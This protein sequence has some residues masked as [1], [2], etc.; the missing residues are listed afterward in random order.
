MRTK[1]KILGVLKDRTFFLC[2]EP[3]QKQI[4][5]REFILQKQN[6]VNRRFVRHSDVDVVVASLKFEKPKIIPR[7]SKIVLSCDIMLTCAT[8]ETAFETQMREGV[9]SVTSRFNALEAS[10]IRSSSHSL[11]DDNH[12]FVHANKN[13]LTGLFSDY[14]SSNLNVRLFDFDSAMRREDNIH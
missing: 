2:A 4:H 10:R 7:L 1:K 14:R 12:S 6:T 8:K 11:A 13:H 9:S 3:L 5:C